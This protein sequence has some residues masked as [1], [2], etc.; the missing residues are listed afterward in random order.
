M[1]K[2]KVG[3]IPAAGRGK[4][5]NDLPLT[6][7]LPKPMLPILNRPILEY[8]IENMKRMGVKDI[9]I[10]VGFKKELIQEYFGN[11]EDFGV[12]IEYVLQ[13]DPQGVA[14]AIGL[15]RDYIEEPFF[16]ILGDDFTITKS[17]KNAVDAFWTKKALVVEG[18][19][20][21]ENVD[22]LRQTCCVLVD[23]DGKILDIEEK[24]ST[25]KSDVRGCGVY[26]FDPMVYEYIERTPASPP[27]YEREIT[28]TIKL[29][30]SDVSAYGAFI[31]GININVNTLPD[32]LGATKLLLNS[33]KQLR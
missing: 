13:P 17:L 8:V 9:Y 15:T 2:I 18:L 12:R 3:L 27:R 7:I 1:K 10:V 5:I 6:R 32:L 19:V 22:K 4:R 23:E 20:R 33:Q 28:N 26:I 29:M 11:G 25:P 31:N 30:A 24:P 16:V 21:E 14:H